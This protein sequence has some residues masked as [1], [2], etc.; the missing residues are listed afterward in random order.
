LPGTRTCAGRQSRRT[1]R[2]PTVPETRIRRLWVPLQCGLVWRARPCLATLLYRNGRSPFWKLL[3]VRIGFAALGKTDGQH[4]LVGAGAVERQAV[5][6]PERLP[7][8]DDIGVDPARIELAIAGFDAQKDKI[9]GIRGVIQR[10]VGEKGFLS[11]GECRLVACNHQTRDTV[12]A[13]DVPGLGRRGLGWRR[14]GG[15]YPGRLRRRLRGR[16]RRLRGGWRH[17]RG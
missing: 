12:R 5:V 7:G 17:R 8:H 1:G 14:F 3:P 9:N 13:N 6:V 11:H 10:F 15:R 2:S 16:W 4:H